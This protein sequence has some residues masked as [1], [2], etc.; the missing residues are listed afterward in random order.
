VT[1]RADVLNMTSIPQNATILGNADPSAVRLNAGNAVGGHVAAEFLVSELDAMR[2]AA[3]LENDA[4]GNDAGDF[5]SQEM[6]ERGGEVVAVQKFEY[7]DTDFRIPLSNLAGEDMDAVFSANAAESSG[8][9]AMA[10]QYAESSIDVPHFAGL[11][12]VSP[13]V[14]ELA[15]GDAI[16][17]LY[18][19]DL[20]FPEAEPYAGYEANQRFIE[21]FQADCG[22]ELP[23]KYA[24]L[25]AQTVLVWAQAVEETESLDRE[26]VAGAIQG[27]TFEDTIL[28]DVTF[29]DLGQMITDVY[30]FEVEGGEIQ[31]L[32]EV[33]VPEEV[34]G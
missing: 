29:T 6:E 31:V 11:G 18:S 32:D 34:W 8:M 9:P 12:T 3:L 27:G 2:V 10:Q 28:G 22:G 5:L 15:G 25:G 21:A 30:A 1:V 14:V 33:E 13:S 23:D 26:T 17:G 20:Y 7:T 19:A 16:D 24:A 4:Y